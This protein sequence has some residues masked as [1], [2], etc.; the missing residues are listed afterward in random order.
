MQREG[1]P[2]LCENALEAIM[3]WS[4]LMLLVFWVPVCTL[5]Y[6]AWSR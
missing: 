5:V 6:W 4:L 3:A 2:R 1:K